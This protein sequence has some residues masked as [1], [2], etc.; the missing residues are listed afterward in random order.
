M[1]YKFKS[2]LM[3]VIIILLLAVSGFGQAPPLI[4]LNSPADGDSTTEYSMALDATISGESP[5]TVWI[6]GDTGSSATDLLFVKENVTDPETINY[7]WS[8]SVF[9]LEAP[10]TMA[11]WHFDD[12]TGTAVSDESGH[13]ND[14]ILR[15]GPVWTAE[16]QFGYALDMDGVNDYMVIPDDTS[17]DVNPVGGAITMEAWVY[18]H[19]NDDLYHRTIVSKRGIHG[20]PTNYQMSID[21][22]TG[23]LMYYSSTSG[24]VKTSTMDVPLNEW[25]YIA[26]T[27]DMAD[28]NIIFYRNGVAEDTITGG[29]I[30]PMTD[31]S[32][33]IGMGYDTLYSLDGLIDEVRITKRSRTARE[34]ASNYIM[35]KGTYYW[36]VKAEDAL[37]QVTTSSI[38][39]FKQIPAYPPVLINPSNLAVLNDNTPD[40]DWSSTAGPGGKYTLE[41]ALD[42]AFTTGV[43]TVNDI[44]DTFY[45]PVSTLSDDDYYWHVRAYNLVDDTGE[46]Q[47]VPFMFTVDTEPPFIPAMIAPADESST[48]DNTPQFIWSNTVLPG[49]TY[50]LQ[51]AQDETFVT[52]VVTITGL[53]D[54]T[55]TPMTGLGDGTWY[56]RVQGVDIADNP[57]GY[58]STPF[59]FTIDTEPPSIPLLT[60]P[61]DEEFTSENEP[62]FTWEETAGADGEYVLEYAQDETFTTGLVT[63][64]G[65]TVAEYTVSSDLDDGLWYWH[66]K[67]IDS[68]DN[69]SD[70]QAESFS[71]TVDTESPSPPW[72]YLPA[73]ASYIDFNTPEFIWSSTAEGGT[74]TMLITQV[75]LFK[76]DVDTIAGIPDTTF[77]MP[78]PMADGT[79]YWVLQAVDK[80][81]NESVYQPFYRFT[82]DTETPAPP[83]LLTPANGCCIN[84]AQAEFTWTATAGTDG[85]Y[86]FE[87]SLDPSFTVDVVTVSDIDDNT[88]TPPAPIG[89]GFWYWRVEAVDRVEHASGYQTTPFGYRLDTVEPTVNVVAPFPGDTYVTLP[90]LNITYTDNYDL[91]QGCYQIDDCTG[92]WIPIWSDASGSQFNI[93][94]SIPSVTPGLHNIYFRVVDDAGNVNIDS[95][96][97]SWYFTY[98][99]PCCIGYRG[100]ANCSAIEQ[101]DVSDITR[102]IDFLYLS[103]EPLCCPDEADC[104]GSGG[105]PDISDITALIDHLYLSHKPLAECP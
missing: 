31:D 68:L 47:A 22:T 77:T 44:T 21:H 78:D 88:Y 25:S 28:G 52:G 8:A 29:V 93:N 39:S 105:D 11:L 59:S 74:Y 7:T 6:Y 20:G 51:Y 43:V 75:A 14:G 32:L 55:Y 18:P 101:P 1:P 27:L 34:I 15:N 100:N 60:T 36:K 38:R 3:P 73:L 81:G 80:A 104:N 57:S 96:S 61:T 48:N 53:T 54:T 42:G 24:G 58:S 13:G 102:L 98:N 2:L 33:Y 82:I 91:Y 19:N 65:L 56:W 49:E 89:D 50:D 86:N 67:A 92:E 41:Y 40:F 95:C 5:L 85:H 66:V 16:G 62:G 103:H 70:Y 97:Y 9:E 99:P 23:T 79:W 71:F 37:A 83:E 4:T 76:S 94:W 17:L 84:N 69:E 72:K 30:G 64:T 26:I 87:Y 12:N 35:M 46:Y 10:Y 45:T 90:S 63:I